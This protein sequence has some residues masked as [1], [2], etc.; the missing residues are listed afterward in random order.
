[1]RWVGS[2]NGLGHLTG[3]VITP[4]L[5]RRAVRQRRLYTSGVPKA[6]AAAVA[7]AI[8]VACGITEPTPPESGMRLGTIEFYGDSLVWSVPAEAEVGQRI[9][10]S[11]RTYGGGCDRKGELRMIVEEGAVRLEPFDYV[12]GGVCPAILR[13]FDHVGQFSVN[14]Q[15]TVRVRLIG[16]RRPENKVIVVDRWIAVR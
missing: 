11:V 14:R 13:L 2:S 1:V 10:V 8:S 4:Q 7:L 9:E 5:M 6:V 3:R 12:G 15:G 16:R